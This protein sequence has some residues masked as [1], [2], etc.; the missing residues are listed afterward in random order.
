MAQRDQ[1]Q[2]DYLKAKATIE[3]LTHDAATRAQSDHE[4]IIT[5][6]RQL[7]EERIKRAQIGYYKLLDACAGGQP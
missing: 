1:F 2:A 3:Q 4:N 7:E 5:L 6:Q